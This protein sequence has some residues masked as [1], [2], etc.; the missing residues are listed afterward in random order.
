MSTETIGKQYQ[1]AG[2]LIKQP[3]WMVV[4][5]IIAQGGK[6]EK[7]NHPGAQILFTVLKGRA[8]V[9]L[10]ESE[11]HELQPGI[12]MNFHGDHSISADIL[13]DSEIQITIIK[14]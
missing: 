2:V 5:K 14:D 12:I 7:H 13:E 8:L 1:E 4:K 10:D 6:I 3:G 11:K 9:L